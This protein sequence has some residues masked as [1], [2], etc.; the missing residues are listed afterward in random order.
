MPW[1]TSSSSRALWW[2][3]WDGRT[4]LR[5]GELWVQK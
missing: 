5:L 2:S 3:S 4:R 1:N